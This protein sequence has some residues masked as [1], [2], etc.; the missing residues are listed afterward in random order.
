M[1]TFNKSVLIDNVV[2]STNL[3]GVIRATPVKLLERQKL[4]YSDV[5]RVTYGTRLIDNAVIMSIVG[6]ELSIDDAIIL[7]TK[8]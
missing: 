4:D 7:G 5:P 2:V 3:Q 6:G 8:L 1:N